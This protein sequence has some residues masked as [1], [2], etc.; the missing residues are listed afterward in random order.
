MRNLLNMDRVNNVGTQEISH[1]VFGAMD[2]LSQ[3]SPESQAVAAAVL[4]LLVSERY[5]A[6]PEDVLRAARNMIAWHDAEKDERLTAM[7]WYL[8]YEHK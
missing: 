3:S 8:K 4:V 5:K 2:R 6:N 7:R 1:A